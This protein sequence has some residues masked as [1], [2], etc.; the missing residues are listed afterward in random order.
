MFYPP[1]T[2][3]KISES[4]MVGAQEM[5]EGTHK[6]LSLNCS[7]SRN[8]IPHN[9]TQRKGGLLLGC[10]DSSWKLGPGN[11]TRPQGRNFQIRDNYE[12]TPGVWISQFKF[13]KVKI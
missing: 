5:S 9:I 11:R 2:K 4:I 12:L 7:V 1:T 10:K 3:S 8:R 6:K 13:S